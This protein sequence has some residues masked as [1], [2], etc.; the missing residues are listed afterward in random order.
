MPP[1]PVHAIGRFPSKVLAPP[2]V[3]TEPAQAHAP[4]PANMPP[5][6][7]HAMGRFPSK[8]L[9]PPDMTSL[10]TSESTFSEGTPSP[11]EPAP[12]ETA[13]MPSHKP[14]R[15]KRRPTL[16]LM[17]ALEDV[18]LAA[19]TLEMNG[20]PQEAAV[21]KE[22]LLREIQA[23]YDRAKRVEIGMGIAAAEQ[24]RAQEVL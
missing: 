1:S 3:A 9:A 4:P 11:P 20:K 10:A 2:D 24:E 18:W 5:S 7:V 12:A 6:P 8:V 13:P 23:R 17:D 22:R 19:R 14:S 16:E 21:F 15:H